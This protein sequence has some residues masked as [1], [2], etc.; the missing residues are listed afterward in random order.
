MYSCPFGRLQAVLLPSVLRLWHGWGLP[1]SLDAAVLPPLY[2]C[3]FVPS[4]SL[5]LP[6][7]LQYFS[8][9]D[10]LLPASADPCAT[11]FQLEC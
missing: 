5:Q 9:H 10:A 3:A 6:T 8:C 11:F 4:A 2:S 1:C 7:L